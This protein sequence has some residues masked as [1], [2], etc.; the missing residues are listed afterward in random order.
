MAIKDTESQQGFSLVEV[1][2]ATG[3][4]AILAVIMSHSISMSSRDG[5]YNQAALNFDLL[6]SRINNIFKNSNICE[7]TNIVTG[8]IQTVDSGFTQ[9]PLASLNELTL[10]GQ[11]I[12]DKNWD[13]DNQFRVIKLELWQQTPPF[14]PPITPQRYFARLHIEIRP[15]RDSTAIMS[16]DI[17]I[18]IAANAARTIVSC[19]SEV[20]RRIPC[21]DLGW[22]YD[23]KKT[24]D[25]SPP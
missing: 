19:Y 17:P 10:G 23:A 14:V 11:K 5:S 9:T 6:V 12:I 21:E 1:L 3:V 4:F 13:D 15:N 22:I 16:R 25:C 8:G 24:P 2:I 7:S 20:S 18:V